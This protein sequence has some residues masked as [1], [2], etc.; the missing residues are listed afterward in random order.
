MDIEKTFEKIN[1]LP[2]IETFNKLEEKNIVRIG[3]GKDWEDPNKIYI[4]E[5]CDQWFAMELTYKDLKNMSKIFGIL[6]EEIKKD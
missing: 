2:E 6:A 3:G 1:K 5:M 4:I